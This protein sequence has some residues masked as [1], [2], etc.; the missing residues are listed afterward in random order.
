MR[1]IPESERK[2]MTRKEVDFEFDGHGV[3]FDCMD[4]YPKDLGVVIAVCDGTDEDTQ[5][6]EELAHE[7][8]NG[9]CWIIP[10]IKKRHTNEWEEVVYWN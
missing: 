10:A 4:Y 7:L 1:I 8:F 9:R 2:L 5:K 6:L 3:L